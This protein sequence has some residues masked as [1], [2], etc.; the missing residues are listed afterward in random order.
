MTNTE[1]TEL[2]LIF[3]SIILLFIFSSLL[4]QEISLARLLLYCSALLLFQGLI[5]D[6]WYLYTNKQASSEEQQA[7]AK[8]CIC[9]ESSIGMT[10][11]LIGT[12][13]LFGQL[14]VSLE[15]TALHWVGIIGAILILGFLMKDLVFYW[16]SFQIRREKNHSNVI[17]TLKN[18]R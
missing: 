4:P 16:R 2:A 7:E 12:V 5:R 1:K 14:N 13:V 11:L 3:I 18:K 8:Q 15:L 10:G 9:L 6:L 17:F